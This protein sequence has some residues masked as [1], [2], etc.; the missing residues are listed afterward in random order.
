[1]TFICGKELDD[2]F[3]R[4]LPNTIAVVGRSFEYFLPSHDEG[5]QYMVRVDT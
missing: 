5:Q 3:Y 1:M 2:H 4:R